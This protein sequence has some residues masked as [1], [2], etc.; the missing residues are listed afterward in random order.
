MHKR[1]GA[2]L[3]LKPRMNRRRHLRFPCRLGRGDF[4]AAAINGF[5]QASCTSDG[6]DDDLLP[7]PEPA[8]GDAGCNSFDCGSDYGGDDVGVSGSGNEGGGSSNSEADNVGGNCE[9]VGGNA[10]FGARLC[11]RRQR[12]RRQQWQQ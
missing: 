12:C 8:S 6:G 9:G 2:L 7:L 4:L 1:S 11:Q 10:E 3:S 5:T